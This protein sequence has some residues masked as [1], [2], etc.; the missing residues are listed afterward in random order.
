MGWLILG[1]IAEHHQISPDARRSRVRLVPLL[2]GDRRG[3]R[4]S[5][6]LLYM[7]S[8]HTRTR[9]VGTY[10]VTWLPVYQ[11]ARAAAKDLNDAASKRASHEAVDDRIQGAIRVS[12]E[13]AIGKG[14]GGSFSFPCEQF[15]GLRYP[16]TFQTSEH[17]RNGNRRSLA[18]LSAR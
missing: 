11:A 4:S 10:S 9:T 16:Q 1:G 8:I 18:S 6:G 3:K 7:H 14:V 2:V 15:P 5:L 17:R 12:Q 13:Q